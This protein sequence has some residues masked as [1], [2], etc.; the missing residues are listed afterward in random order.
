LEFAPVAHLLKGRQ[1]ARGSVAPA[2]ASAEHD[3]QGVL[4]ARNGGQVLGDV[5]ELAARVRT[6]VRH[7]VVQ[8]LGGDALGRPDD[9]GHTVEDVDRHESGA[10]R[11][12]KCR[13][14]AQ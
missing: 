8:H 13:R 12:G 7:L 11:A 2:T 4:L 6:C 1:A 10:A 14:D 5:P 9:I 3:H